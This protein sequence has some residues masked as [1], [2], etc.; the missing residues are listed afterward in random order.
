MD[1]VKLP[2]GLYVGLTSATGDLADN[3]DVIAFKIWQ[4]DGTEAGPRHEMTPF[5]EKYE[6]PVAETGKISQ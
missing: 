5:V 4:L 2:T 1:G 3:H 6:K